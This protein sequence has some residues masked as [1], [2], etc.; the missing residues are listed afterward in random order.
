M[1]SRQSTGVVLDSSAI[2][3]ILLRERGYEPVLER[4]LAAD[5]VE[6][7]S[8]TATETAIVL[9]R[10]IGETAGDL[11]AEFFRFYRV[12]VVPFPATSWANAWRAY[13]RFGKGRHPARLNF[14]DCL[15]YATAIDYG[16]PLLFVGNEFGLTDVT[17]A[18]QR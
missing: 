10:E 2:L 3:A 15:T 14:G 5:P 6:I 8:P 18:L 9:T 4:L 12:V 16:H 1:A 7:G 17:P 13:Q 11:L